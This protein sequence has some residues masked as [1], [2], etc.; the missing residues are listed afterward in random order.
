MRRR[1]LLSLNIFIVTVFLWL[2]VN[3]NLNYTYVISVPLNV[4]AGKTQG[5]S[6]ELPANLEVTLRGKGWGILKIITSGNI[7]YNLDLSSYKKD[8]RIDLAQNMSESVILPS[9]VS[10]QTVNPGFI[11][12]S[13]D[14]II[15]K[16][17][18]VKN[19]T[20]VVSRDGYTAV[21]SVKVE[22]DSVKI[23]GAYSVLSKIKYVQTEYMVFSDVSA[24]FSRIVKITDT[25]G[26]RVSLDPREVK[27][28]YRIE[29]SAEKTLQDIIV[30]VY[31]VPEDKEVLIIPPKINLTVRGGVEE[32]SR[33]TVSDIKVG[34]DF[35]KIESDEKG[36]VE[37]YIELSDIFTL[38]TVEPQKFQYI[39]KKKNKEN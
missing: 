7:E 34:V 29:L 3:L 15:T 20:S 25:L 23:T 11:D 36:F 26:S 38:I 17:I 18:K 5:V 32:L 22:P 2:Y 35:K 28:S 39:I 33:L 8:S 6:S 31:D 16:M 1:V 30:S 21:G 13:F 24:S 14:N 19:N 9:D 10:V 27:V 4:K 37:P 12:V